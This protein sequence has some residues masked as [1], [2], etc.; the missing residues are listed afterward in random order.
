M[1]AKIFS[2]I[3]AR[4]FSSAA[5]SWAKIIVCAEATRQELIK[6]WHIYH[7]SLVLLESSWHAQTSRNLNLK[8]LSCLCIGFVFSPP[9]DFNNIKFSH[10]I[11]MVCFAEDRYFPASPKQKLA[12]NLY[13][14]CSS[15]LSYRVIREK[16][17][18]PRRKPRSR[19]AL[20]DATSCVTHHIKTS[21]A[22]CSSEKE[23]QAGVSK[24]Q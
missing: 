15:Q 7:C 6:L 12:E 14:P 18:V 17:F 23:P 1:I 20:S 3:T 22:R 4:A 11:Y 19:N 21:A 16:V 10:E 13:S 8:Q 24:A 9:K 5:F 2:N